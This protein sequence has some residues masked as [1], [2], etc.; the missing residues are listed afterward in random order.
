MPLCLFCASLVSDFYL[1]SLISQVPDQITSLEWTPSRVPISWFSSLTPLLVSHVCVFVFLASWF[2][3]FP[4]ICLEKGPW[5]DALKGACSPTC[6]HT[7]RSVVLHFMLLWKQQEYE[8]QLRYQC[9]GEKKS[10]IHY[11]VCLEFHMEHSRPYQDIQQ[12]G[13]A[14]NFHLS[15]SLEYI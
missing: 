14:S 13:F 6:L 4:F 1:L 8:T 9:R 5:P 2:T 7:N 11:Y 3:Y 12:W 15:W 10:C